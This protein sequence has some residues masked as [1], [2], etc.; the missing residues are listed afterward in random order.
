M[1][2][3]QFGPT[4]TSAAPKKDRT[5]AAALV[6]GSLCSKATERAPC[7]PVSPGPS[8]R[9]TGTLQA[10]SE[11][12]TLRLG[13]ATVALGPH[14][15]V[16]L[17]VGTDVTLAPGQSRPAMSLLLREGFV[18]TW[19]GASPQPV[20]VRGHGRAGALVVGEAVVSR[21]GK[22]LSAANL[23]GR[24]LVS[25]NDSWKEV[26]SGKAR[27]ILASGATSDGKARTQAPAIA[28]SRQVAV[29]LFQ[30][31]EPLDLHW[32][33]VA[34]ATGYLVSLR[35]SG[36]EPV[37]HLAQGPAQLSAALGTLPPGEYLASVASLDDAGL[38]GE[39]SPSR[40]MTVL[41]A[42]LPPG[43]LLA[44]DREVQLNEGQHV[45]LKYA[46][47]VELAY[48]ASP[49]FEA[50]P[51][52]LAMSHGLGRLVRF[53]HKTGGAEA[54]LT[55]AE[56]TAS[57]EVVLG[58]KKARWPGDE[59]TIEIT[60]QNLPSGAWGALQ[61]VPHVTLGT[62][63]TEVPFRREG[64]TWR[65]VIPPMSI[66]E[67]QALRVEVTDQY[68]FFLGRGFLELAPGP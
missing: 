42:Q 63:P 60:L 30:A 26:S 21:R 50:P 8:S 32:K 19:P 18:H 31:R 53:R 52:N 1:V 56:R 39:E 7:V 34:G 27:T 43:A 47:Q 10:G 65:A 57:A 36:G 3:S 12:A 51:P 35:R 44:P 25:G 17:G 48:G 11:G 5:V 29:D 15:V 64:L 61:A 24:L 13:E 59:V 9:P 54:H 20:M 68:G 33:P 41:Q 62:V 16:E 67:Y 22:L 46:K 6:D 58:P 38:P 55:I 40:P 37:K 2:L 23:G 49:S 14:A 28:E 4:E 45:E 66:S